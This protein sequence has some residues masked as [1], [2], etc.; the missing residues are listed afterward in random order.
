MALGGGHSGL[1]GHRRLTIHSSRQPNRYAIGLRLN[2]GVRRTQFD[3]RRSPFRRRASRHFRDCGSG[4]MAPHGFWGK[5][6]SSACAWPRWGSASAASVLLRCAPQSFPAAS[7]VWRLT[8]S[9]AGASGF[10]AVGRPSVRVVA[11]GGYE[12]GRAL[13]SAPPNNSFKRKPLRGSA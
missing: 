3:F 8:G 7:G 12:Q 4:G 6:R 13:Q 11:A 2:S 10:S 5:R 1:L 9:G